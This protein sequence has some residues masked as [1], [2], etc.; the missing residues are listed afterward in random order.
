MHVSRPFADARFQVA[1][2]ALVQVAFPYKNAAK[3]AAEKLWEA[4]HKAT[5]V[6]DA[7]TRA[8]VWSRPDKT[9][10]LEEIGL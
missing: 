8:I 1:Q 6:L 7:K 9:Q 5:Y 10:T 3:V 2:G 4:S